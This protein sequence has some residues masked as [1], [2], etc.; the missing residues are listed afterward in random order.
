[1]GR[2]IL[3]KKNFI[4]AQLEYGNTVIYDGD[5]GQ[6]KTTTDNKHI[7]YEVNLEI[8]KELLEA[9]LIDDATAIEIKKKI[10]NQPDLVEKCEYIEIKKKN[11]HNLY[12]IVG[13]SPGWYLEYSK[14]TVKKHYTNMSIYY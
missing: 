2:C 11:L 8:A 3:Y 12:K 9:V 1:M 14:S 10:K 6:K 13:D 5:K 7:S 4:K